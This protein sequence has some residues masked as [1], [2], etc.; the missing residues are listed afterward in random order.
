MASVG[1]GTTLG[2]YVLSTNL[3]RMGGLSQILSGGMLVG[4]NSARSNSSPARMRGE[5]H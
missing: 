2:H 1:V 4:R 5:G 3:H